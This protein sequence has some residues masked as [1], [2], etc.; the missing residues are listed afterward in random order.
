MRFILAIFFAALV[1][2]EPQ[3]AV[4][5]QPMSILAILE[6]GRDAKSLPRRML[7][8]LHANAGDNDSRLK[9]TWEF[10]SGQVHRVVIVQSKDPDRYRREKTLAFETKKICQQE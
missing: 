1:V 7:V 10:S 2:G 4:S 8:L 6:T 5:Q 3:M 9:E